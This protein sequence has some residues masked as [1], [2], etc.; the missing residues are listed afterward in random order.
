MLFMTLLSVCLSVCLHASLHM[1]VLALCMFPDLLDNNFPS[2]VRERARRI[3][4]SCGGGS[5][6]IVSVCVFL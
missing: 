3:R 5:I 1:Q 2:D 6:G 4:E